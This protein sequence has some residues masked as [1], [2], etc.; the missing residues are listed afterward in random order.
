MKRILPLIMGLAVLV[1]PKLLVA[2]EL[3]FSQAWQRLVQ[4]SDSL[5]AD[6]QKVNRALAEQ[7]A[8]ES[9][10]L[11]SLDI[12]G[13]YI[14]LEKPLEI[15]TQGLV[16]PKTLPPQTLAVLA[17]VLQSIGTIGLTE[18]D[19]FRA[20]LRAMWPVY[21]G[22]RITAAQAIHKAEVAE[23]EQ[24][25]TLTQ[26]KLFTQLAERYYGVGVSQALANTQ[27]QL[28]DS[29]QA[30]FEHAK[31]LEE[32]GQIARVE[33][34]NAQVAF[35]NAKV[36]HTS[37]KR[38]YEMAKIALERMLHQNDVEAVSQLFMLPKAPSL[39]Q[40]SHLTLTQ[41]PA[42][43]LLTA[44][45]DQAKGL[46]EVEQGS[47]KP[48]V[49]LYG[50]YT[51]YEDDSLFAQM[52]PDWLV[53]VGVNM[54]IISRD[55]R[56]GKVLAAKSA[57]LQAK[58]TKAQTRQ[59]LSLLVDQSYRSL[60]QAQEEYQALKVSLALAQE[61]LRLRDLA[62]SQGL[63]TS[64]DTVDAEL[65]LNAVKTQQLAAQYRYVKSYANLMAVSGQLEEF[66]GRSQT[67]ETHNAH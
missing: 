40:L 16:D 23:Q 65:K 8:G 6:T 44:K 42:L 29:L 4:V 31:K 34:L 1:S 13:T 59:D 22:G 61:N 20:S 58:H 60:Q 45:E 28:V 27:A 25:R 7:E 10:D 30:H 48:T 9:L 21:T 56:S 62:F 5:Q 35:E 47:Y 39:P 66:I 41:H 12:T 64:I 18:Q 53:G 14:H 57:L 17:P 37:A 33:L 38:H 15:H 19:V 2:K 11:P 50:N 36:S 52:E 24:S 46:I 67:K 43:K 63:S 32:Q 3:S 26:R 49:F 51:L 54:P 55:G